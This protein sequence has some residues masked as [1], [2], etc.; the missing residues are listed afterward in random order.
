M[1]KK[2]VKKSSWKKIAVAT[3]AVVLV[4]G[5]VA[6]VKRVIDPTEK[7]IE[8][9]DE[10]TFRIENKQKIRLYGIDAPEISYCYGE[11]SKVALEKKILGKRVVLKNPKVDYYGRVQAY[12]YLNGEFINEY[13]IKNG[14]A[15]DHGSGDSES[16]IIKVANAYAKENKLGIYAKT[17]S[18]TGPPKNEC[19]IKAQVSYHDGSKTFSIPGC[20]NY[21]KTLVE[22]FRGEDW[23]CKEEDAKKA[24]FTKSSNCRN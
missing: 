18:P 12:V 15:F 10:D 7:V 21:T 9:F 24:G 22:R 4:T 13:L 6:V 14:F 1:S 23:F 16:E 19:N 8:V 17:C 11:E 3:A 2:V 5:G 20:I